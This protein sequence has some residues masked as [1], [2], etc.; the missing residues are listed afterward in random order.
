MHNMGLRAVPVGEKSCFA[1][2]TQHIKW[3]DLPEIPHA[4]IHATLI[5]VANRYVY[6]IGGFEDFY[7]ECYQLDMDQWKLDCI[8]EAREAREAALLQNNL[9][10]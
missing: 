10:L 9:D 1:L 5:S 4:R 8:I 7:F 3:V 6:Q 2:D